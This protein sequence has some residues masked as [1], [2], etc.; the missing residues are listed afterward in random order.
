VELSTTRDA[1]IV[2]PLGSFPAFYGTR[3][4]TNASRTPNPISKRST[5]VLSIHLIINKIT[6]T[7]L[8]LKITLHSLQV[9]YGIL[10]EKQSVLWSRQN[11]LTTHAHFNFPSFIPGT[12]TTGLCCTTFRPAWFNKFPIQ[13]CSTLGLLITSNLLIVESEWREEES[14]PDF[15]N[16]VHVGLTT[17][18][19]LI[20]E[21]TS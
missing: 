9:E 16:H 15:L 12:F 10:I 4:F 8:F 20:A 19:M 2:Q 17:S 1:K 11:C 18:A 13:F 14:W 5:L 3:W 21:F 7:I 6:M